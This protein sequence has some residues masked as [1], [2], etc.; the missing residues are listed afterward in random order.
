[1][2][3]YLI[4]LLALAIVPL[5][6]LSQADTAL[7]NGRLTDAAFF[8]GDSGI[9]AT[10]SMDVREIAAA[11]GITVEDAAKDRPVTAAVS[12]HQRLTATGWSSSFST[13]KG[14]GSMPSESSLERQLTWGSRYAAI[15]LRAP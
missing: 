2:R 12:A 13:R 4:A 8:S 5:P 14:S 11:L 6:L 7:T 15:D 10:D 3:A 1:M 9:A